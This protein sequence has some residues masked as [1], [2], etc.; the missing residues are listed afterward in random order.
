VAV[1]GRRDVTVADGV[2]LGVAALL[3]VV[4]GVVAMVESGLSRY[5]GGRQDEVGSAERRAERLRR[6][7]AEP[8][9]YLAPLV[10]LQT[11]AV[12]TA[13]V[14]VAVVCTDQ[15]GPT[16]AA[17]LAAAGGTTLLAYL[18]VDVVARGQGRDPAAVPRGYWLAIPVS[19]VLGPLAR[20]LI[21]VGNLLR[22]AAG[23][24]PGQFT[25]EA[26]LRRLVDLAEAGQVIES[27]ERQMI[28]S[29]FELGDTYVREVMVP[30]TDMVWIERSKSVRQALS[31]AL[32]SGFSRIPVVGENEDDV[33][34]VAYLKDLARRVVLD[35]DRSQRVD[36]VMRTAYY[37]PESK[38]V[39]ELLREMQSQQ[40][41]VAVVIDEYGGTAG[42]VTIEDIL[43]EIVGEIADEYDQE[44]PRIERVDP[45]TVRVAARLPVDDLAELFD[46]R[47]DEEDV[48]TVGGLI[49][50]ALGRVPIPGTT[51]TVSGL[52]LS[53][54]GPGGRRNGISTVLV[55]RAEP[56]AAAGPLAANG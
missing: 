29:V 34:G 15:L 8:A 47:F 50:A 54:E 10:L 46:V 24:R 6:I 27:D 45:D 23:L 42:L 13:T 18:L 48:E 39:D 28:H 22:P 16:W 31:L 7:C 49:A 40:V 38:R 44:A 14:L 36:S 51:V 1:T 25:S 3:L 56:A 19:V 26:E 43:E 4:A 33:V 12:L 52:E 20:A 30:R 53:A 37:V 32:R 5:A 17:V 9:R 21:L 35:E 11:G 55:R 2:R 41:H